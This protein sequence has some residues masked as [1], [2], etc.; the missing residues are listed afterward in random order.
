MTFAVI[1]QSVY[2]ALPLTVAGL[3]SAIKT[4][5]AQATV[6]SATDPFNITTT[7]YDDQS[8]SGAIVYQIVTDSTKAKG[9]AYFRV[10]VA[11]AGSIL[12]LS[13]ALTDTWSTT[14]HSPLNSGAGMGTS[15]YFGTQLNI[16]NPVTITAIKHPEMQLVFLDQGITPLNVIGWVRPGA[17]KNAGWDEASCP[18]LFVPSDENLFNYYACNSTIVP[19]SNGGGPFT[20]GTYNQLQ[21]PNPR[22]KVADMKPGLDLMTPQNEGCAG[23]FSSDFAL[24]AFTGIL[25]G[26][27]AITSDG[28]TFTIL[29]SND[30]GASIL[31]RTA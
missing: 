6:Q 28:K 1:T 31:V 26:N 21:K 16:N 29:K 15:S 9:T 14:A 5:I 24:G 30:Y 10:T 11:A 3:L 8:S 7:L 19:Y 27:T 17:Y 23:S 4:A 18:F 13:Q 25:R 22:T 20:I 12:Q 2:S